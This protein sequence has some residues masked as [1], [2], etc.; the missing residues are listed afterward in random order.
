MVESST[1]K[2]ANQSFE[3]DA[4]FWCGTPREQDTSGAAASTTTSAWES[5]CARALLVASSSVERNS[6]LRVGCP[7]AHTPP[8]VTKMHEAK[9]GLRCTRL[10]TPCTQ[11]TLWM[12]LPPC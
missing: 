4:N 5:R 1:E 12:F 2:V 3:S 11:D 7:C 9:E 8:R 10:E 6:F